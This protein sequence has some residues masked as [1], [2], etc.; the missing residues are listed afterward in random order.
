MTLAD[1][2]QRHGFTLIELAATVAII[3]IFASLLLPALLVTLKPKNADIVDVVY[4][5]PAFEANVGGRWITHEL[6]Q[7]F[8][9]TDN[10]LPPWA[11][12]S[13]R[14]S[15]GAKP[16]GEV[17]DAGRYRGMPCETPLLLRHLEVAIE[18]EDWLHWSQLGGKISVAQQMARAR[19]IWGDSC[20][21]L[22]SEVG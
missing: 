2:Q 21:A 22:E 15:A 14:I 10:H 16:G 8:P 17:G 1:R 7:Q 12:G 6:P 5:M 18:R 9:F 20:A 11:S 13:R 4:D 3:A 19:T